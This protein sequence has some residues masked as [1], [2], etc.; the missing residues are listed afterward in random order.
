MHSL[1]GLA[2]DDSDRLELRDPA[3]EAGALDDLNDAL[4]VLV[5]ERRLF[6]EALVRRRAHGDSGL[7]ELTAKVGSLDLLSCRGAGEVAAGAVARRP[8]GTL[9]RPRLA[10]EDE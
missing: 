2:L 3:R 8:E 10:G 4:D 1:K 7:L 9:H 5:G 6:G